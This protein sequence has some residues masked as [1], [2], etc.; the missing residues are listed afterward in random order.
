MTSKD[1]T[2]TSFKVDTKEY[3]LLEY[4]TDK[5]YVEAHMMPTIKDLIGNNKYVLDVG[6]R[7]AFWLCYYCSDT[8]NTGVGV[9][10]STDYMSRAKEIIRDFKLEGKISLMTDID[11]A[12]TLPFK[13]NSF[14]V[15]VST[16]VLEHIF[17]PGHRYMLENMI[18]VAREKVII[19]TPI[20]KDRFQDRDRG[21]G[22][23]EHIN[24]F[25]CDRFERFLKSFGYEY[26]HIDIEPGYSSHIGIIY[27][28]KE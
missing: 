12:Y 27:L 11:A 17:Y 9:D 13:D 16:A 5:D 25:D 15:A 3:K 28:N 26:S 10:I 24:M 6:V 4:L 20:Y 23:Q 21:R 7:E 1:T 22:T 2:C 19:S 18:R 8:E 14:N